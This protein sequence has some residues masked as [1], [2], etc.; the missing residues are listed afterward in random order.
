MELVRGDRGNVSPLSLRKKGCDGS[1]T[2]VCEGKFGMRE[3]G[4]KR[5]AKIW[6]FAPFVTT[7]CP[8]TSKSST[9]RSFLAQINFE[10]AS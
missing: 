5:F 4:K 1:E 8:T 6:T 9:R 2:I 3:G 10:K 7:R